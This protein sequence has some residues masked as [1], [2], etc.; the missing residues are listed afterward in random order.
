MSDWRDIKDEIR[1]RLE[2]RRVIEHL[3]LGPLRKGSRGGWVMACPFHADKSPSFAVDG[4]GHEGHGHC[5]GCGW[6]GDVFAFWQAQ[7]GGDFKA[8]VNDLAMI[9][10]VRLPS[11][12]NWT[13]PARPAPPKAE[14]R[15]V[16]TEER[17]R[18]PPLR[19]LREEECAELA[20]S[21]GLRP[22]AVWLAAR[23]YKRAAFSMWPMHEDHGG[24]WSERRT[25]AWP[26]WCATDDTRNCAEFRR[27]DNGKYPR[28]DGGEIKTWST[29]GK[30]WPLGAASLDGR[31][32]VM[33]VEGG[34]DMLA[35]YDLLDQH[36]MVERVA[37]V[38]MLG[39]GNRMREDALPHFQGCRVRIMVDADPLKDQNE[40]INGHLQ[41][42]KIPGMEAAL[43][44]QE[45]LREAGAAVETFHIGAIYEPEHLAE[46]YDRKRNAADVGILHSGLCDAD[47]VPLKDV[48]DVVK[49]GA[50]LVHDDAMSEAARCWD[51]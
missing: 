50:V 3:N 49:A 7:R 36:G 19:H 22:A 39:A 2:L 34:P 23:T 11:D 37:V 42:R 25:G 15:L 9:A 35:A 16:E 13:M 18:L 1:A 33:L 31:K 5:F 32:A 43:R 28:K 45:Q 24:I 20:A 6:S 46:W 41:P 51:F 21:R 44:W 12:V 38:C 30:K 27:L 29:S 10:G 26:S 8:A 14:K 47:G 48:N 40:P 4:K 17:P